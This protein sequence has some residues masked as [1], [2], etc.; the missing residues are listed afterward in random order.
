MKNSIQNV[1]RVL[2]L[3]VLGALGFLLTMVVPPPE[4][5]AAAVITCNAGTTLVQGSE[6]LTNDI[7]TA[8]DL[9]ASIDVSNTSSA[10]CVVMVTFYV[11]ITYVPS[12]YKY[13]ATITAIR[14]IPG[15]S[16]GSSV[17]ATL[18][19]NDGA[20]PNFTASF[21]TTPAV[22]RKFAPACPAK[23]GTC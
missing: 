18:F 14:T 9:T 16:S 6:T 2:P 19:E 23:P 22:L 17:E 3:V 4:A 8:G 13:L 7:S 15:E 1:A 21:S 12:G 11:N 5:D 20:N 10:D